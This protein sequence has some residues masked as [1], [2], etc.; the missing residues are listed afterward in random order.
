MS[1]ERRAVRDGGHR[2][3]FERARCPVGVLPHQQ[4]DMWPS[5]EGYTVDALVPRGDERRGQAAISSGEPLAGCNP[6][7]SEWGNPSGVMS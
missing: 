3:T 5:Y 4:D 1:V 7:I 6:E 2:S